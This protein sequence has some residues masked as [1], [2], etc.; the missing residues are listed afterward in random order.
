[1]LL[2]KKNIYL[3]ALSHPSYA[4]EI[5]NVKSYQRLEFLGDSILS[6]L[7]AEKTSPAI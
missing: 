4:N 1:M 5:E 2:N 6:K 7:S 3:E